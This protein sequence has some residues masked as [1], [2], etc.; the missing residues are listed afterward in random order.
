MLQILALA[1]LT[2]FA[3]THD[4]SGKALPSNRRPEYVLVKK[5]RGI[6]L[7]ERWDSIGADEFARELKATMTVK[8]QTPF[9]ASLIK[10]QK[11]GMLWNRNC[12]AYKMQKE[13]QHWICYI[14]YDMPWPVNNQDCVLKYTQQDFA[15]STM[16]SFHSVAHPA[17]PPDKNVSRIHDVRGKWLLR[18]TVS[19]VQVEYHITT[20]PSKSIPRWVTD[21]IIR[22]NLINTLSD[23]RRILEN[24]SKG[25]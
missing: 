1:V 8:T 2:S 16:I 4:F 7:Y 3:T 17:F 19:G 21:P 22:N 14:Q 20:T 25:L 9:V 12:L 11:R 24:E 15:D 18:Q 13:D 6:E 5:S 10:D 23:F